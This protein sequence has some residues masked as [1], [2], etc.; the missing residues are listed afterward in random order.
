MVEHYPLS[1]YRKENKL[2]TSM[3]LHILQYTPPNADKASVEISSSSLHNAARKSKADFF[4]LTFE[5]STVTISTNRLI[6][7]L[8]SAFFFSAVVS[9][10]DSACSPLTR[11]FLCHG[12]TV[13]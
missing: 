7:G 6:S 5:S 8:V 1:L 2:T 13:R 11:A 3:F 9:E 10:E 12:I 4:S